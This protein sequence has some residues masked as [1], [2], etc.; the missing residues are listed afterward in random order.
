MKNKMETI[1]IVISCIVLGYVISSVLS[2]DC[3]QRGCDYLQTYPCSWTDES[4]QFQYDHTTFECMDVPSGA[5]IDVTCT[6]STGNPFQVMIFDKV[7][8]WEY[9]YFHDFTCYNDAECRNMDTDSPK[10]FTGTTNVADG[11]AVYVR[12]KNSDPCVQITC[13]VSFT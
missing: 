4:C 11:H 6:E 7:N 13:S 8:C 10:S 5:S 2:V 12:M 3:G 9:D 1:T